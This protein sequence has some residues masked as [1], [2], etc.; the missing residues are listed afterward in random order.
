MGR[1][2]KEQA[3]FEQL[4]NL[5]LLQ[6]VEFYSIRGLQ[7]YTITMTNKGDKMHDCGGLVSVTYF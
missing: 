1:A 5:K 6:K 3:I 2:D 7:Q 4:P